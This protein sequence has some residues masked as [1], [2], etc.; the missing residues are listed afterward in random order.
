[1]LRI[2]SHVFARCLPLIVLLLSPLALAAPVQVTEVEGISQ[3]RLDNGLEVLLFPDPTK[4]TVTVNMTYKVGSRHEN[5]GETGMA[6]LLEHLLFKGSAKHPDIPAELSARGARPNGTTWIDRTNYFETFAA[7]DDN[8]EWALSLE[9]DRMV[10][11]F[12]RAEDLASEMTV[13]R[14]EFERAENS[15]FR[16]LMQKMLGAGYHWHKNGAP[17][18]GAR[19]DIENVSIERLR[20]FYR[21]YYQPDNAVLTVAG[22][23]DPVRMLER[24]E[25]HFGKIPKPERVLE[26]QYTVEPPADGEK[27]VTVRRVGDEQWYAAVYHVPAGR[28]PDFAAVELLTEVLGDTPRGRLHQNLVEK[29]LAVSTFGFSFQLHDPGVVLLAAQVD[30]GG[31][32]EKTRDAFL[33]T[34]EGIAAQPITEAEVERARR[35]WLKEFELALNSSEQIAIL[36]SEYI[37]MGDWR[38][39]FLTRDRIEQITA[40]DV[41]RVAEHYLVRNNRTSG[42]FLPSATTARVEV[43]TAPPLAEMLADY[44]GRAAISTGEAFDPSYENIDERTQAHTLAPGFEVA[45]LPKKTRGEA[46]ELVLAMQYGSL[47]SLRGTGEQAD[48]AADMLLRGTEKRDRQALQDALDEHRIQLSFSGSAA[49]LR[50]NLSTT[51][52]NLQAALELL[53]EVVKTPAFNAR[54]LDLWRAEAIAGLEARRQEPQAI[55]S[56]A[57]GRY[58]NAFTSDHPKYVPTIDEEIDRLKA[59]KRGDLKNFHR[60][61]YGNGSLQVAL[62]GDFDPELVLAA[63]GEG[64]GDFESRE[65]YQRVEHPFLTRPPISETVN[66]PDKENGAIV[67]MLPIPVGHANEAATALDLATYVFGGGFLNSRLA[68]RLRQTD[69]LSYSVGAWLNLS[70]FEE[71]GEFNSYAIFAPQNAARV[72]AGLREELERAA[73]Q[74][75]KADELPPAKSGIVQNAR[76][77]RADD[78][79]LASQLVSNL[80]LDRTMQWYAQREA[81]LTSLTAEAVNGAFKKYMRGDQLAVVKALDLTRV[82]PVPSEAQPAAEAE[83]L[84]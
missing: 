64:F 4:E 9:A 24:I 84:P 56:R 72:E 11:S 16:V 67:A 78:A 37:G 28:H 81:E 59:I 8:I 61:F 39:L 47:E 65:V 13:V 18:I 77:N 2:S 45:L 83:P 68:T 60:Q 66:T 1:M 82:P 19:S 3:Y 57:M 46:V 41:Q 75:F 53:F 73:A 51:R 55:V 32:L 69:G 40:A 52:P 36:L 26:P 29:N 71:R 76:V 70:H 12:I 33:A 63:L 49:G 43:S 35:N 42:R 80:Y 14:N 48:A 10:N 7:T 15:P 54:E 34:V 44:Q 17:T 22:Q 30:K 38:L 27:T 6:H 50:A 21:K 23:F 79:R 74:G 58:Y 31:D 25:R 5:Y 20:A 62:V